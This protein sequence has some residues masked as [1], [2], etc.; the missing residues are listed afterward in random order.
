M[1]EVEKIE[2]PTE[3]ATLNVEM[4]RELFEQ[5]SAEAKRLQISMADFMR[6]RL[7]EYFMK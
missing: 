2:K 1:P 7:V 6:I 5:V 3:K 4:T